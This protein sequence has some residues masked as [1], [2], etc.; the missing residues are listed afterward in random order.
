MIWASLEVI[1]SL[2]FIISMFISENLQALPKT[3]YLVK[4]SYV[5]DVEQNGYQQE[6]NEESWT[7]I[8]SFSWNNFF[9]SYDQSQ[10]NT[11]YDETPKIEMSTFQNP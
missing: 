9:S 1:C 8:T 11:Y 6:L 4:L 3:R 10:K 7:N 5:E 2:N